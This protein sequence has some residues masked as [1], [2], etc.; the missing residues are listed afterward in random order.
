M[1]AKY[2]KELLVDCLFW[3]TNMGYIQLMLNSFPEIVNEYIEV[4]IVPQALQT[5]KKHQE[6]LN[7]GVGQVTDAKELAEANETIINYV[8]NMLK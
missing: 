3:S 5:L 6:W 1:T 8:E 4:N 7:G 2:R